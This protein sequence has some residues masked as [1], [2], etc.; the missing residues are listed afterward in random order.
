M[1]EHLSSRDESTALDFRDIHEHPPVESS[2]VVADP[3]WD[4]DKVY[5]NEFEKP[6]RSK[7][8]DFDNIFQNEVFTEADVAFA[9]IEE[10][11]DQDTAEPQLR[12]RSASTSADRDPLGWPRRQAAELADV[13]F[14]TAFET[15]KAEIHE[16]LGDDQ[17]LLRHKSND[18]DID[19]LS[20]RVSLEGVCESVTNM[21]KIQTDDDKRSKQERIQM[22]ETL[23]VDDESSV[24]ES[25]D[26]EDDLEEGE[27]EQVEYSQQ[28]SNDDHESWEEPQECRTGAFG[29]SST[30]NNEF[31]TNFSDFSS[32]I[33]DDV[34]TFDAA[35][36]AA[37]SADGSLTTPAESPEQKRLFP[38]VKL[39][40]K[41]DKIST[42][43]PLLRP[44]P[45]EKIQKWEDA[46]K[47]KKRIPKN[48][49]KSISTALGLPDPLSSIQ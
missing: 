36:K 14:F 31:E 24:E 4:T 20:G 12:R 5:F 35:A 17:D 46:T 41:A 19:D 3:S 44:P 21:L 43:I 26:D 49:T 15:D 10:M 34:P 25:E 16:E 11:T 22:Y 40:K 42:E 27:E 29:H 13:P 38:K 7:G 39:S 18:N 33:R 48:K 23:A 28:Q 47:P 1:S 37:Q 2:S 32:S 45:A 9:I 6:K 8:D 30:S